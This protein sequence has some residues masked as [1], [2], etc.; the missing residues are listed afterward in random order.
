MPIVGKL[1]CILAFKCL[2]QFV[3]DASG[4]KLHSKAIECRCDSRNN[5]LPKQWLQGKLPK[6][7]PP[8]G[9]RA[10]AGE[11]SKTFHIN[12]MC[13]HRTDKQTTIEILSWWITVGPQDNSC[14]NEVQEVEWV[15]QCVVCSVIGYYEYPRIWLDVDHDNYNDLLIQSDRGLL[16]NFKRWSL[17]V[18]VCVCVCVWCMSVW[19]HSQVVR[20]LSW[21]LQAW[22]LL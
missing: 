15:F 21:S 17:K 2:S 8:H 9:T 19:Y 14:S 5:C 6:L 20:A 13:W 10:G 1:Q 7:W 3:A 11:K 16:S 12:D 22:F 18:S 4:L